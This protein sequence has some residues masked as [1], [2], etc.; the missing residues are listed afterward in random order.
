MYFHIPGGHLY[1]FFGE[2][3]TEVLCLFLDY[4]VVLVVAVE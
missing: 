3:L 2:M 4:L 1:A